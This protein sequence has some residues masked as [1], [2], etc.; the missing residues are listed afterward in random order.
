M[1]KYIPLLAILIVGYLAYDFYFSFQT[2]PN[3]PLTAQHMALQ[4]AQKENQD[5]REKIKKAEEFNRT[6][7]QKVAELRLLSAQLEEFKVTLSEDFDSGLYGTLAAESRRAGVNISNF[8]KGNSKKAE[9]YDEISY[10]VSFSAVYIQLFVFLDRLTKLDKI[11]RIGG[12]SIQP[13]NKELT[14]SPYVELKGDLRLMTY[15]YKGTNADEVKPG[16]AAPPPAAAAP[17]GKT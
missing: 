11:V 2:S 17:K 5:Y 6:L 14:D 12:I 3:S 1:A 16:A 13:F 10:R 7:D 9:Y 8:T 15:R 4:A